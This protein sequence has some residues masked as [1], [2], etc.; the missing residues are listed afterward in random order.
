MAVTSNISDFE[1]EL[2][3]GIYTKKILVEGDSWVSHPLPQAY[4]LAEQIDAF[5]THEY[6]MLNIAEPGDEAR[7]IFKPHGRQMKRLKRLL[8]STQWGDT[9]DLILLSAAG[10]D[11]VGPEIRDHGY[12]LNKRDYPGLYGKELMTKHFYSAMSEVV[13]GYERFL[14]MRNRTSLNEQTPV[15]THVYSYLIPREIGTHIGPLMFN[16]GWIKVHLKHQG[17]SDSDEQY[18]II[19]EMLDAFYRRMKRIED[20]YNNF[21]VV[22]TRKVLMKHGMPDLDL[23]YDEIHPN[24]KGFKKVARYIRKAAQDASLWR[25]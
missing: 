18:E 10:N 3:D 7:A 23:W 11:I 12:V 13:K 19:V 4:N 21:L 24:G 9:F 17:I 20:N 2:H 25:L 5:D 16:K 22:D 8:N 6:L 1:Q 15:I 14:K